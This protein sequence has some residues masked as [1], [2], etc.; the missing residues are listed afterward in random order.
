MID[1]SCFAPRKLADTAWTPATY[2]GAE[3]ARP[4]EEHQ[5]CRGGRFACAFFG[6]LRGSKLIPSKWRCLVPP[7]G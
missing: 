3:P 2:A 1:W 7:G 5:D 4:L 6:S